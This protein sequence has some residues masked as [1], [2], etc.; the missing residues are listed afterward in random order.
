[1]TTY[2]G[3]VFIGHILRLYQLHRRLRKALEPFSFSGDFHVSDILFLIVLMLLI[4]VER[5]SHVDYLRDDPLFKKVVELTRIPHRTKISTTLKQFASDSLKAL[6]ELNGQLV[7][8][9]LKRLGLKTLTI[10]FD[11]TVLSTKGH[12]AWAFA[13]YNPIKKGAKSYFPLTVHVAETGHFLNI[14]NRPGNIHDSNRAVAVIRSVVAQMTGYRLRFRADAAFCTPKILDFLL[15]HGYG[16]AIKAPFWKLK[17]L[18]EGIRRRKRWH[19]I[20][21]VWSYYWDQDVI[22][23]SSY[24]HPVLVLRKKVKE[25]GPFQ[26]DL[27][28]PNN[29]VYEYS[30]IVTDSRDWD[31]AFLLAFMSGRSAQENSLSELKSDFAFDAIPTNHYAA[32]SAYL[33]LS[34]M[35]YN[36]G[37]SLQHDLGL[38][39]KR[40]Q[41]RKKTRLFETWK[42]KTFRW[43]ILNRAGRIVR[44]DGQKVLVVSENQATKNLYRSIEQKIGDLE[45]AIF[46]KAA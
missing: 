20:D 8:E 18:R 30:A 15:F 9:H 7:V 1:M 38:A 41:G 10:D 16:F 27:F 42:M 34:Q 46:P 28:S 22:E 39:K 12:P 45:S 33:Q 23:K 29:G 21:S 40:T 14:V 31:P 3:L 2:S 36:L 44:H 26:L 25:A 24:P 11:G 43:L 37:I 17:R 35:A 4:G 13:G 19:K 5:L 6:T 32:N